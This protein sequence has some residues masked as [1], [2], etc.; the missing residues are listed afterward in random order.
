[1]SEALDC[2]GVL[3]SSVPGE[4][5]RAET[6]AIASKEWWRIQGYHAIPGYKFEDR[7]GIFPLTLKRCSPWFLHLSLGP[8][9]AAKP[10]P[11]RRYWVKRRSPAVGVNV[12]SFLPWT[13]TWSTGESLD[14]ECEDMSVFG[15]WLMLERN[16]SEQVSLD[17]VHVAQDPKKCLVELVMSLLFGT[18]FCSAN[19]IP[20]HLNLCCWDSNGSQSWYMCNWNFG[21]IGPAFLSKTA[22][23][24][25]VLCFLQLAFLFS[26]IQTHGHCK[27]LQKNSAKFCDR[28]DNK[29]RRDGAFLATSLVLSMMFF[30]RGLNGNAWN[31]PTWSGVR[32]WCCRNPQ[33]CRN[34]NEIQSHTNGTKKT[35]RNYHVWESNVCL[36]FNSIKHP[37]NSSWH[38]ASLCQHPRKQ[39]S[40]LA[41]QHRCPVWLA[42]T[43]C[44][45]SFSD[46]QTFSILQFLQS[47]NFCTESVAATTFDLLMCIQKKRSQLN[48]FTADITRPVAESQHW[49]PW[50]RL[51]LPPDPPGNKHL[52]CLDNWPGRVVSGGFLKKWEQFIHQ[53]VAFAHLSKSVMGRKAQFLQST[54]VLSIWQLDN[55]QWMDG[56]TMHHLCFWSRNEVLK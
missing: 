34:P 33:H 30:P 24:F 26:Y 22:M 41:S 47:P 21:T 36:R 7:W 45:L 31:H 20:I 49:T 17:P 29:N 40:L 1:M 56:I 27:Q 13:L 15:T 52:A 11:R 54:M 8:D 46:F 39:E 4:D 6:P 28:N 25:T 51:A 12:I 38:G 3:P 10:M 2:Y 37:S 9:R 32:F 16:P 44:H 48:V 42:I 23:L 43:C 14:P 5:A 35:K 50:A 53:S 55:P 18:S 19:L